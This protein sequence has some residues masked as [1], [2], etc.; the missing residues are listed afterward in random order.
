MLFPISPLAAALRAGRDAAARRARCATHTAHRRRRGDG[1][2][3]A[4]EGRRAAARGPARA[5][6]ARRAGAVGDVLSLREGGGGEER[7]RAAHLQA[8]GMPR[9]LLRMGN[10]GG[11]RCRERRELNRIKG[12]G[13]ANRA[14]EEK[15]RDSPSGIGRKLSSI[16][17]GATTVV[18]PK[19]VGSM[20][21]KGQMK[22]TSWQVEFNGVP[23][24]EQTHIHTHAHTQ[25]T[26]QPNTTFGLERQCGK[27]AEDSGTHSISVTVE[28]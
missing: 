11:L 6:A 18:A 8:R 22:P 9:G 3:A 13:G 12:R 21:T 28:S 17:S 2:R 1:F 19:S 25:P 7:E 23:G 15:G 24:R 26:K 20:T 5:G 16:S 10:A 4:A 14:R 27:Q